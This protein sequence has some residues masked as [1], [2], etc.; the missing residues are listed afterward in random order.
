MKPS[1]DTIEA[2]KMQA[3]INLGKYQE[4]TRRWKNKK[5]KQRYMKEGDLVLQR[6]SKAKQKG[7]MYHKWEGPFIV[8][9]M[10]R[11]EACRLRTLEGTEDPYSW[12]KD[13]LQK[14][15]V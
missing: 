3:A 9:S 15:Y 14:Y 5:V 2:S 7:N 6:I 4:E 13:I 11:P 1:I 12:N 8:A 10:A